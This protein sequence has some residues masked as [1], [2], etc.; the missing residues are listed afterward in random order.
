MRHLI[1]SLAC[2]VLAGVVVSG[3]QSGQKPSTTRARAASMKGATPAIEAAFKK[4]HPDATVKHVAKEKENGREQ[5]EVES[6]DHGKARDLIYLADGT[7]IEMEEEV[8]SA[9]LPAAVTRA[10]KAKYSSATITKSERVTITEGPVIHYELA[11]KGAPV[12]SVT[13]TTEGQFVP[14]QK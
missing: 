7:L 4:A 3:A 1:G 12:K 5:Y 2:V 6:I 14:A 13:L 8:P 10:V 11:L 9:E